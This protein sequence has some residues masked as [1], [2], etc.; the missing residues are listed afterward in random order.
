M[1]TQNSKVELNAE[2]EADDEVEVE[3]YKEVFREAFNRQWDIFSKS[4]LLTII[5]RDSLV[6][7]VSLKL[8]IQE[9]RC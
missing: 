2:I 1:S 7:P 5:S 9:M 6:W 3:E 4:K 8:V